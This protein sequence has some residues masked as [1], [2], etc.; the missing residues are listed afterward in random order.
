MR[1]YR[2]C[3]TQYPPFDGEGASR[4]GGRWNSKGNRVIYTSQNRSLAVLEILVHLSDVLPDKYVLASA[5]VPEGLHVES[6]NE[7]ELPENWGTLNVAEQQ[8]T[9]EIGDR[10]LGQGRSAVLSVPSV[11]S[12]ERNFLVNPAHLEFAGITP[13]DAVPF[14]L[15]VRLLK[16]AR[17]AEVQ[18]TVQH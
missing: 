3:R 17:Y 1:V 6:V 14:R 13:D 18:K 5:D 8:S 9:R 16:T 4:F 2:L 10:W 15:D 7:R 12:G 11:V